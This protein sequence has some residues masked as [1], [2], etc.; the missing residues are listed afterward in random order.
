MHALNEQYKLCN[1]FLFSHIMFILITFIK[2]IFMPVDSNH[3]ICL[4][5]C[6]SSISFVFLGIHVCCIL[7]NYRS[8][9]NWKVENKLVLL[10]R[11]SEKHSEIIFL[12]LV[13][14][15]SELSQNQHSTF[16]ESL[17]AKPTLISCLS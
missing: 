5:F 13:W 17:L 2:I 4:V 11:R 1:Y 3:K 6:V 12:P 10:H 15:I 9:M 14:S 7:R 16:P 8:V